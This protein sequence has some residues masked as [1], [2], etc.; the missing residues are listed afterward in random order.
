MYSAAIYESQT[1]EEPLIEN[2]ALNKYVLFELLIL[3]VEQFEEVVVFMIV[4]IIEQHNIV[5]FQEVFVTNEVPKMRS[6]RSSDVTGTI[7]NQCGSSCGR[8]SRILKCRKKHE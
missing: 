1:S 7:G 6:I 2:A 5:T 3:I 4:A 8:R